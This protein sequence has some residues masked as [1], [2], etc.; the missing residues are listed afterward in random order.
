MI[1]QSFADADQ[2]AASSKMSVLIVDGL[3]A[4]H[5]EQHNAELALR[6][7]RTVQLRLQ[8]ADEAAVICKPRERIAYRHGPHLFKQT[9]LVQQSSPEHYHVAERLTQLGE[10][11]RSIKK[12]PRKRCG[13]VADRVQRSHDKQRI[14][15]KACAAF[16]FLLVLDAL[17]EAHSRDQVK[18]RRE[19]VPGAGQNVLRVGNRCSRSG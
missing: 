17:A 10:K 14:V 19:Q 5:V 11:K 1:A 8:N 18:P 2:R 12:L 4:V 16:L 9:S 15:E 3:Q 13:D 6:A 7:A